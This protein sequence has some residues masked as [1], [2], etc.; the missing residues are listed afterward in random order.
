[1]KPAGVPRPATQQVLAVLMIPMV[2]AGGFAPPTADATYGLIVTTRTPLLVVTKPV[3]AA[4]TVV[5]PAEI[6]SNATPPA[7]TVENE[8]FA[9]AGITTVTE[10]PVRAVVTSCPN[11]GR[12]TSPSP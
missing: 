4:D 6:A 12:S 11:A 2:L 7:A 9:P 3:M 8:A 5:A 1:M 10:P